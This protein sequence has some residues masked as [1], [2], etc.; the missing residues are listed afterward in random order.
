MLHTAAML[1]AL[2]NQ[3]TTSQKSPVPQLSALGFLLNWPQGH[4]SCKGLSFIVYA[5]PLSWQRSWH[6]NVHTEESANNSW[7]HKAQKHKAFIDSLPCCW[8]CGKRKWKWLIEGG[9]MTEHHSPLHQTHS[10]YH[11]YTVRW[12]HHAD[13]RRD[14]R[15]GR[16]ADKE[17]E[18]NQTTKTTNV[19]RSF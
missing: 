4:I 14:G 17:K 13:R 19:T 15:E 8:S 2:S 5:I 18:R 11:E 12:L 1:P 3:I 6:S 10:G 7:V 9:D 16:M